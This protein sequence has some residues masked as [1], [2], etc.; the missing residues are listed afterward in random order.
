MEDLGSFHSYL[1]RLREDYKPPY[2]LMEKVDSEY[3][4]YME[5]GDYYTWLALATR[6]L[7]PKRVLELGNYHGSSTIMIYSEL[8]DKT[9]AFYSVDVIRDLAFVPE[10]I[11]SDSRIIFKFGNDLNLSI[12]GESLPVNLDFL[13]ID[14]LHEY[15][16]IRDEWKIYKNLCKPGAIV[17]LDDILMNDMPKFWVELPYPKMDISK[18][19][20]PSGF[21]VFIYQPE[22]EKAF[23]ENEMAKRAYIAALEVA[24]QQF[25]L[26]HPEQPSLKDRSVKYAKALLNKPARARLFRN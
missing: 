18:D 12:Y 16:Q 7:K 21:G 19:C 25:I 26:K 17:I 8:T 2:A 11:F 13:F 14:T 6:M 23:N 15:R 10:K 3:R 9:E 22:N 24:Y 20:H 1:L 5:S 4:H